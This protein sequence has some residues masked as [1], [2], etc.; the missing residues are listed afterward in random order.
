VGTILWRVVY[1]AWVVSEVVVI[2]V[3]RT[4]RS[5]GT[6]RD[7]GSMLVL[8]VVIFSSISAGCWYGAVHRPTIFGGASWVR[9]ASL[10][11]L[12]AGVAVRWTAIVSLGRAFS[13][14][15][16][17]HAG[18]KLYRKGLFAV[19]RHPSYTGMMII[20]AAIGV[21]TE[22]WIALGMILAPSFA[23]LLYRM[24]VEEEALRGAF[25]AEYVEYSRETKR[26]VPGIY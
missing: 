3:T 19:V 20:F 24:H 11:I 14:N 6:V 5:S 4:R 8:W 12:V 18:Q 26:L 17:I 13:V 9:T 1:W 15:V 25:G 2:V 10:G 22:N 23:A 7:R 16:A 21:R